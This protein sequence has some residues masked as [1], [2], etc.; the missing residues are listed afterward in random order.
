MSSKPPDLE[1]DGGT[2]YSAGLSDEDGELPE[3]P[4]WAA[5]EEKVPLEGSSTD[6]K[7]MIVTRKIH[8]IL[9]GS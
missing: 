6:L 9:S 7:M 8:V 3:E 2:D 5:L 1:S 4:D